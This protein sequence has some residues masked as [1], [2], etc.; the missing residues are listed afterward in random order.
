MHA[1]TN[2]QSFHSSYLGG[3]SRQAVNHD[4]GEQGL[5]SYLV[6]V[7]VKDAGVQVGGPP[8]QLK[9]PDV[10]LTVESRVYRQSKL[11]GRRLADL[12]TQL[13]GLSIK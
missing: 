6:E 4:H 8:H 1:F 11:D 10:V 9:E 7:A 5:T 13:L 2:T 3:F 12:C